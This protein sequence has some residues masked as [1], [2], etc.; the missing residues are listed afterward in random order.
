MSQFATL[1]LFLG[2]TK[3]LIAK[4]V[5]T[6]A[7]ARVAFGAAADFAEDD[8]FWAIPPEM[9]DAKLIA[10]LRDLESSYLVD[11]PFDHPLDD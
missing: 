5:I 11:D 1:G 2:L 9:R 8:Q 6:D 3:A 7:D 10:I 4:G